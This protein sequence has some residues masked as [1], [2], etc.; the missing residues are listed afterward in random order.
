[1]LVENVMPILGEGRNN[2]HALRKV[3]APPFPLLLCCSMK[4]KFPTTKCPRPFESWPGTFMVA[5]T[6]FEPVISALRGRC[7][8]PLDECASYMMSSC[9]LYVRE[10]HGLYH[11]PTLRSCQ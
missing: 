6:G 10:P 4:R 5:H 7:P 11:N 3:S 9:P 1:M 2:P 8:R